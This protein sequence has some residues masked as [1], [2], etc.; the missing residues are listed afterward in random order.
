MNTPGWFAEFFRSIFA[1]L[2]AVG[3][4]LL[5]GIYDVFFTVSN[6]TILSGDTMNDLYLR[7]QLI[8][9]V[10]MVFKLSLTILNIIINPIITKMAG[11]ISFLIFL[12]S[13]IP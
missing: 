12:I 6:A 7:L 1:A 2:D 4:W 9:G 10:F 3:Y 13:N 5:E 8:F 11:N